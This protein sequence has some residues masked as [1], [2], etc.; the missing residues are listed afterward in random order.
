MDEKKASYTGGGGGRSG[1]TTL[2]VLI[3]DPI[4]DPTTTTTELLV[5]R[6][7]THGEFSENSVYV[8]CAKRVMRD[9]RNWSKLKAHQQEALDMI[10]HKIGRILHGDPDYYDH[11]KD[12]AGYAELVEKRCL[13]R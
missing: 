8:Q 11:W 2:A 12:I 1:E 9:Q 7:G 3:T 13:K 4:I 5:S 6:G 10:Q